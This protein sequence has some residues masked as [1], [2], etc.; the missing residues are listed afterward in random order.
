MAFIIA[1]RVDRASGAFRS[2]LSVASRRGG[3]ELGHRHRGQLGGNTRS[4]GRRNRRPTGR[5]THGY[6]SV[7]RLFNLHVDYDRN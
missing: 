6:Q 1:D 3:T 4:G 7:G 5:S 2:G